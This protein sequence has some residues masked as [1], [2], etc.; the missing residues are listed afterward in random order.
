MFWHIS[1]ILFFFYN[2]FWKA[3]P[4]DQEELSNEQLVELRVGVQRQ[5]QEPLVEASEEDGGHPERVYREDKIRD[6]QRKQ[7]QQETG[8]A[9][10]DPEQDY[11]H[12]RLGG[13]NFKC[14]M[15][16]T[17]ASIPV[18]SLIRPSLEGRLGSE[19]PQ[20]IAWQ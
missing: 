8:V 3:D 2:M 19:E 17:V 11:E 14:R 9:E 20:C 6:M 7:S 16:G 12:E 18:E 1:N 4:W 15:A 5:D 13:E 10:G